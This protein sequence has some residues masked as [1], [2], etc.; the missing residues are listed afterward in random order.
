MGGEDRRAIQARASPGTRVLAEGPD[1]A[2]PSRRASGRASEA[3]ATTA[4]LIAFPRCLL[5]DLEDPHRRDGRSLGGQAIPHPVSNATTRLARCAE[6]EATSL[7]HAA[8]SEASIVRG[9]AAA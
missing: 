8:G 4:P 3:L 6:G 9:A 2:Y 7:E 5:G 1:V